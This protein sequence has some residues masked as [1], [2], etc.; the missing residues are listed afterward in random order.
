[1][2]TTLQTGTP[3]AV[4][5]PRAESARPQRILFVDD[6]PLLARLG[7]QFLR[8]LG[9]DAVT[10]TDASTALTVFRAGEFDLVI[11]DLTMPTLSGIQFGR[12]V[13]ALRPTSCSRP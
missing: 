10:E 2:N 1:M 6:E 13:L 5:K 4:L 12:E 8:K 9:Y 11:T 7:G 3:A